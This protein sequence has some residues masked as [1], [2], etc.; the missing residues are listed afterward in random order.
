[1]D[2]W[3]LLTDDEQ[4]VISAKLNGNQTHRDLFNGIIGNRSIKDLENMVTLVRNFID[5][6]GG[7]TDGAIWRQIKSFHSV[8]LNADPK[9]HEGGGVKFVVYDQT[10]FLD[11]LSKNGYKVNTWYDR[12][13]N[14]KTH[15]LDSAREITN[16]SRETA[17]HLT[18]DDSS[19]PSLFLLHWDKRSSEFK[20]VDR[21]YLLR[22]IEQLVAGLSHHEP[23]TAA[24]VRQGL[25]DRGIA[26]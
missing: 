21:L 26:T 16:T 13:F 15:P 5:S 17:A 1:M 3:S 12:K 19:D 4:S 22:W 24:Q 10:T 2:A 18:N 6:M 25:I 8:W 7:H 20:Q 23:F 9:F 11:T 14:K